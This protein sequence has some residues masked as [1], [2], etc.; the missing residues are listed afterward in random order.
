MGKANAEVRLCLD[1][2][3]VN[4]AVMR[5]DHLMQAVDDHIARLDRGTIQS[6]LDIKEAFMQ[7][8]LAEESNDITTFITGRRLFRFQH[9][10]FGLVT[11]PELFQKAMDEILCGCEGVAWYLDDVIIEGKDI[12]E[13]D[14]RLNEVM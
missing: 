5:E 7:N 8:E 9:L 1:L 10:P 4:E 6:K 14:A 11:A 12:E 3:R 2:R 13:H